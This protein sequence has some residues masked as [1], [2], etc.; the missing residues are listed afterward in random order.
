MRIKL[1]ILVVLLLML[2][3]SGSW[4]RSYTFLVDA[5][6][7]PAP[8]N[9]NAGLTATNG[10]E[11][12]S[13]E[14]NVKRRSP[15]AFTVTFTRA[16]GAA[17]TVDF[18]FEASYDNGNSWATFDGVTISIATNHSVVSGTTVS[19]LKIIRVRGVSHV[20]LKSVKNNDGVNNLTAIN[21]VLSY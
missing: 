19:V 10:V 2:P 20:R 17:D 8:I 1:L 21:V 11:F 3:L 6:G 15:V 14:L 5:D 16:A 4:S 12:D 13:E 7:D 18:A 9:L